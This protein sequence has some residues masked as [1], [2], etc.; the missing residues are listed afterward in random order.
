MTATIVF[1]A[2]RVFALSDHNI[3][4]T[5]IVLLLGLAPVPDNIVRFSRETILFVVDPF[6][7]EYCSDVIDM[8]VKAFL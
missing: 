7:G 8:S 6:L 5:I 4:L 1:S 3:P 2:L